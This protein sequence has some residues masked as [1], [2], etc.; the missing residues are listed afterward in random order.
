MSRGFSIW[1]AL[2]G[3]GFVGFTG[4][5]VELK[6]GGWGIAAACGLFF[7]WLILIG[8]VAEKMGQ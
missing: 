1:L 2:L 4:V 3:G 8:C 5:C 6:P 7:C